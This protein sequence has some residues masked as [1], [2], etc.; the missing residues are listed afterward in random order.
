MNVA[1]WCYKWTDGWIVSPIGVRYRALLY[2]FGGQMEL[3]W[4]MWWSKE[5]VTVLKKSRKWPVHLS[6][7]SIHLKE[8]SMKSPPL[9]HQ[10]HLLLLVDQHAG[11][12][13]QNGCSEHQQEGW[14]CLT[15]LCRPHYLIN[16]QDCWISHFCELPTTCLTFTFERRWL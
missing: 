1:S 12:G 6:Q 5:Q 13:R 16:L 14:G 4:V 2:T 9:P 15:R 3:G 10:Q 11:G 8:G 7:F